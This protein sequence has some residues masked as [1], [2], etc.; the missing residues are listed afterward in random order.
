M[1]T[2]TL[3]IDEL[4]H[5]IYTKSHI[6]C[7]AIADAEERFRTE[8]GT[9][10]KDELVRQLISVQASLR[11]LL[12][13][14]LSDSDTSADNSLGAPESFQFDMNVTERQAVGK[15]QP[16]ADN[17]HSYMVAYTLARYYG[18][19]GAKELSNTYSL[20]TNTYAQEIEELLYA[21]RPP[22]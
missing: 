4:L 20:I 14:Y 8:A 15:A 19:V 10:K 7:Q 1:L 2:I 17:C 21:K 11:R 16:M 13:R 3:Y 12:H 5:D 9:E 18:S 22:L 6:E